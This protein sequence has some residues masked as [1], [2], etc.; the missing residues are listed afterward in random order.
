MLL[1]GVFVQLVKLNSVSHCLIYG[2][3]SSVLES[4]ASK[5]DKNKIAL[6]PISSI[7]QIYILGLT[8]VE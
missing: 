6:I 2:A 7:A 8:Q 4:R 5:I 3:G 1:D